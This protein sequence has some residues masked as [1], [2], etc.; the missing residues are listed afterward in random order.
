M[1]FRRRSRSKYMIFIMAEL[2]ASAIVCTLRAHGEHGVIA[3]LLTR[4][5]GLQA[6]YVQG[7]RSKRLR[8]ILLPGNM[9]A[10]QFRSR[11]VEQLAALTVELQISRAPLMHEPLPAAALEW[12]TSLTGMAL[13]EGQKYPEIF[14][15]LDAVLTAIDVAGVARRWAIAVIRYEVL[16]LERLGYGAQIA[17]THDLMLAMD[18]N[19]L[20]LN[21]HI[22]Q[23]YRGD[24]MAALRERLVER[25]RRAIA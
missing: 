9:V 18:R 12:V 3:R 16:L 24:E 8:P 4:E 14:D 2:R 7:G 19:R 11:T 23:G 1:A 21:D 13:P 17:P 22:L 20:A 5:A 10:A 25:L 6:G 15:A